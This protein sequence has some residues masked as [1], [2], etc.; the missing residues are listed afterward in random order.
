MRRH[1]LSVV[2]AILGLG[3][4]GWNASRFIGAEAKI[5]TKDLSFLP[6]PLVGKVLALGHH[7]TVAKL[8][9]IDSFA[10]FEL[11]LDRKDDTLAGSGQSAFLRL[12]DLLVNLDGHFV[13]FYEHAVLNLGGVQGRHA[14]T[15]GL[16]QRGLMQRPHDPQ[17]WRLLAVELYTAYQWEQRQPE[18]FDTVLNSWHDAM[19]DPQQAQQVWDWKAAFGRR[20]EPGLDQIPYW[21]AQLPG[22]QGSNRAFI[23]QTLREQIGRYGETR[24]SSLVQRYKKAQGHPPVRLE[25][26][27]R[28]DLLREEWPQGLPE[29]APVTGTPG[30]WSLRQDPYGWPYRIADQGKV[31]SDG[32]AIFRFRNHLSVAN[33][34]LARV[35]AKDG[36]WPAT[37]E[38]AKAKG[39]A[40]PTP[41]AGGTWVLAEHTLEVRWPEVPGKAWTP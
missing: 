31:H 24:L 33:G 28:M 25:D 26:V 10:F 32:V 2:M 12:Y 18:A 30:K 27:V 29:L 39:V 37:L 7:N 17:L 14:E 40:L 1:L 15:L 23:L 6:S 8:R 16:L 3:L 4:I 38:E 21:M 19:Q 34:Q 13:P 41:P 36:A 35:A 5:R 9:W 22:A 20:R 11:Q